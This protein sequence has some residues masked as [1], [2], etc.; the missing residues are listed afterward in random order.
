MRFGLGKLMNL[1]DIKILATLDK[2]VTL[3][4]SW[5]EGSR[6]YPPGQIHPPASLRVPAYLRC[7]VRPLL[8][9]EEVRL[10]NIW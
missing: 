4:P 6:N 2:Q 5:I 9:A 10:T 8:F 1:P 7:F 3:N